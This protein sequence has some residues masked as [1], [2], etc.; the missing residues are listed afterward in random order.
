MYK[1]VMNYLSKRLPEYGFF[2]LLLAMMFTGSFSLNM[3]S[4][5][6]YGILASAVALIIMSFY[7]SFNPKLKF[8]L[9]DKFLVAFLLLFNFS[10]FFALTPYGFKEFITFNVGALIYFLAA[11]LDLRKFSTNHLQTS[12]RLI[13]LGVFSYGFYH[14]Y[15]LYDARFSS[16]FRGSEIYTTYP[17]ALASLLIAVIVLSFVLKNKSKNILQVPI[18]GILS[19]MALVLTWSRGAF[20]ALGVVAALNF[21]YGLVTVKP[22]KKL[23]SNTI[24]LLV[25]ASLVFAWSVSYDSNLPYPVDGVSRLQSADVSS[26]TS[27][28]ERYLHFNAAI[29]LGL[30]NILGVGS[31]G[32]EYISAKDQQQLLTQAP[33]AH[34]ILLKLWSENGPIVAVLFTI[35]LILSLSNIFR[36]LVETKKDLRTHYYILFSL[37]L[38]LLIHNLVDYNL[39]FTA[40]NFIFF[41]LLGC[42]KNFYLF[43]S[44][45]H[46][47]KKV[48]YLPPAKANN[49]EA[50][51]MM[52][53]LGIL[54]ISSLQL[55]GYY[56]I[57]MMEDN[58]ETASQYLAAAKLAPFKHMF[59]EHAPDYKLAGLDKYP[60]YY[61]LYQATSQYKKALELNPKNDLELHFQHLNSIGFAVDPE[62]KQFY[63]DLL[64]E[65]LYLLRQNAH[66]TVS[67]KNPRAAYYI[68]KNLGLD[69]L[70]YDLEIAHFNEVEKFNIRYGLDINQ[71]EDDKDFNSL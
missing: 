4:Q 54:V 42:L 24:K 2:A 63:Q 27:L 41:A 18:M 52:F 7:K 57:K 35:F 51:L 47:F 70:A 5:L 11:N 34:N 58:P 38:G 33:H 22:L 67:T 71:F 3:Q 65:Y 32:Y 56:N 37:A 36:H 46:L 17:N 6:F 19:F 25:V 43:N 12:M 49:L 30:N 48:Q 9:A 10:H 23:A 14:M 50:G 29:K 15:N 31:G 69:E 68:A 13:M 66:L 53:S 64:T 1:I 55:V 59:Y 40:L 28:Q 45:P 60:E 26:S 20:L 61:P 62:Q 8:S 39:N 16:F 44:K 21:I